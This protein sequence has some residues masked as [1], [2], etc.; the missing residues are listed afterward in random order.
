ML[1]LASKLTLVKQ[2]HDES[3]CYERRL[4]YSV[5]LSPPGNEPAI[6][7]LH[8][9]TCREMAG[10]RKVW[11]DVYKKRALNIT[12]LRLIRPVTS[13]PWR[14]SDRDHDI[15]PLPRMEW[16]S[17]AGSKTNNFER[18]RRRK[19]RRQVDYLKLC[20]WRNALLIGPD[21]VKGKATLRQALK[22]ES[23]GSE[24]MPLILSPDMLTI[25]PFCR[26]TSTNLS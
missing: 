7:V 19:R 8:D 2:S 21:G 1:S 13:C 9:M 4:W 15:P 10:F 20:T 12:I 3:Q 24:E 5:T 18:M 11:T 17:V 14:L 22:S 23:G 16:W 26:F 25:Q 6:T